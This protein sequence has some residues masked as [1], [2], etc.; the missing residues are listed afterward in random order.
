VGF[1]VSDIVQSAD[2]V[3][4]IEDHLYIEQDHVLGHEQF[5]HHLWKLHLVAGHS[6]ANQAPM[7]EN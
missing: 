5:F 6:A 7:A 1:D 2:G 3:K 4:G